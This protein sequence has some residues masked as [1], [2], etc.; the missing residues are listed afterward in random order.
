[1]G[2]LA[3]EQRHPQRVLRPRNRRPGLVRG[4]EDPC[5]TFDGDLVE[6]VEAVTEQRFRRFVEEKEFAVGASDENRQRQVARPL[7][8]EDELDG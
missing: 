8:K 5:E 2:G 7:A 3:A 4:D 1:M 6:F